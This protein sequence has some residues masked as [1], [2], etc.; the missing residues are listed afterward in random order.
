V[1]LHSAMPKFAAVV[2]RTSSSSAVATLQPPTVDTAPPTARVAW[3][4]GTIHTNKDD[5]IVRFLEK[6]RAK[7]VALT[8]SQLQIIA[9][10]HSEGAATLAAKVASVSS[11]PLAKQHVV[12]AVSPSLPAL[13]LG[14]RMSMTLEQLAQAR[15]LSAGGSDALRLASPLAA[16]GGGGPRKGK[17]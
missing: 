15:R 17:L 9:R 7:G 6:K 2:R 14:D 5:A 3:P 13:S 8:E 10:F 12:P 11:S 1:F 16:S 4:V